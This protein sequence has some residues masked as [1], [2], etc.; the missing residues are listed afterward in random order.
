QATFLFLAELEANN[1]SA[2]FEQH[3]ARY[4]FA[5]REPLI[6]LCQALS[7]RYVEPILCRRLGWD[8]GTAARAGQALTSINSNDHGQRQ[9]YV[10]TL[11]I[12][13][14]RQDT[15]RRHPAQP[16]LPPRRASGH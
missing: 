13:F 11:W 2:W 1:N 8:V 6:E 14:C 10:T 16:F 5:V 9:P 3:R 4:Q 12:V 15:G 7:E